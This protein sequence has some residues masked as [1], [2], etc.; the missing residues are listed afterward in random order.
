MTD[1]QG[2][3]DF[4][5]RGR[6]ERFPP[7]PR[8]SSNGKAPPELAHELRVIHPAKW[9][10]LPLPPRDWTVRD[11]IPART[12]TILSG[13][14]AAGKTTIALQLC[15]ARA[16][17]QMWL[18]TLPMPG[19]SLYLSAEDDADE[20][21]RRFDQIRTHYGAQFSELSDVRLIDL[22][23]KDAVLD[24]PTRNGTIRPTRLYSSIMEQVCTFGASLLVVDAVADA[25]GGNEND[26]A[27][28]RQ[29]VNLLRRLGREHACTILALAPAAPLRCGRIRLGLAGRE[30]IR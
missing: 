13:D 24:V 2:P 22:V 1:I 28:V 18:G 27:Q 8:T 19:R 17:K 15:A 16:L 11:M 23:G 29:F 6:V 5:Q 12:V 14:G 9:E 30:V 3:D 26:R 4:Q 21:H 25:F 20:L 7:K 10:G